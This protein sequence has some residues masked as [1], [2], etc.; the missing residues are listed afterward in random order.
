MSTTI[1]TLSLI[2]LQCSGLLGSPLQYSGAI[3]G[4]HFYS[5]RL[6]TFPSK[7]ITIK[8]SV[9]LDNSTSVVFPLIKFY[10][11]D[12][13]DDF[14]M[15]C[16]YRRY[17]QFFNDQIVFYIWPKSHRAVTCRVYSNPKN[18]VCTG[19][20]T[21]QDF[22]PRK[23]SV[24]FGFNCHDGEKL[25]NHLSCNITIVDQSNHTSYFQ[26][27]NFPSYIPEECDSP[28][29]VSP[30]LLGHQSKQEVGGH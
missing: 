17:G 25:I 18:V 19:N 10:T 8:F 6:T 3:K 21:I 14:S 1:G 29:S 4:T 9:F 27:L 30:N 11:L 7:R 26:D 16:I 2:L 12:T 22:M 28:L 15:K 24:S 20:L 5:R 13:D 23:Y